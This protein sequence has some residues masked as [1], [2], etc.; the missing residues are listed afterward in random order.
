MHGDVAREQLSQQ[1]EN[2]HEMFDMQI[3]SVIKIAD[4]KKIEPTDLRQQNGDFVI[5]PL[6]LGLAQ[7]LNAKAH[8]LTNDQ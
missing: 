7:V 8:L 1:L 4:E 6:L 3:G 2:L 5:A